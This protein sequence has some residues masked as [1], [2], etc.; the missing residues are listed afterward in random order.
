VLIGNVELRS[1]PIEIWTV[2]SGLAAFY[3]VGDAFEDFRHIRL[4]QSTGFGLRVV[5]PQFQRSVLRLDWGFPLTRPT[6]T[7]KWIEDS[8]P[9]DIILTFRQAFDGPDTSSTLTSAQ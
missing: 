4:K 1:K 8:F 6:A 3:D 9:G 2:Q 5:F 7:D